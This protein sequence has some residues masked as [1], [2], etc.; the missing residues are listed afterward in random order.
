MELSSS[1]LKEEIARMIFIAASKLRTNQKSCQ[2]S[3]VL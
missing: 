1:K 3:K 2:P